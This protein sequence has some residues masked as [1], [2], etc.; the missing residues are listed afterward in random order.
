[1]SE[2]YTWI[3]VGICMY[4]VGYLTIGVLTN[5]VWQNWA[6]HRVGQFWD[7]GLRKGMSVYYPGIWYFVQEYN[8][9]YSIIRYTLW[10]IAIPVQLILQTNALVRISEVKYYY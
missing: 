1:M 3:F 10:P 2:I 9:V 6:W 7:Y 4:V 5:Y 8:M